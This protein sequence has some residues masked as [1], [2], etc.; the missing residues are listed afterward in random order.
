MSTQGFNYVD[1]LAGK[2]LVRY[3]LKKHPNLKNET[4]GLLLL[5]NAIAYAREHY[6]TTKDSMMFFLLDV[7]PEFTE[8]EAAAFVSS[9]LLTDNGKYYKSTF[10]GC[11]ITLEDL[12]KIPITYS[13][14]ITEA[15]KDEQTKAYVEECI[16]KFFSGNY[17]DVPERTTE[18]NNHYL[19]LGD[20]YLKAAYSKA[21]KLEY[22]IEIEANF[23]YQ[24]MENRE[25]TYILV[26]YPTEK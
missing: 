5:E 25:Q 3:L 8:A 10:K 13:E 1:G 4:F 17:G 11:S 16:R 12:K 19:E 15:C 14:G 2:E 23:Y 18:I 22:H 9:D 24:N 20:G 6:S 7:I 26:M 21:Y